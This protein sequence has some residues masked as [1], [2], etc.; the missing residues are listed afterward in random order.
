VP[1]AKAAAMLNTP[2]LAAVEAIIPSLGMLRFDSGQVQMAQEDSVCDHTIAEKTFG[3][4]MRDF[5]E[6]LRSY[7]D[8]I[9]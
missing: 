9:R 3:M 5:E 8:Q 6:E 4:P 2:L 7:A 1:V